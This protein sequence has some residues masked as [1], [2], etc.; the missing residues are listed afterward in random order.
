[1]PSSKSRTVFVCEDCGAQSA[2]W[3]GRCSQCGEWNTLTE[4]LIR[5]SSFKK[6]TS[7]VAS[8]PEKLSDLTVGSEVR[9]EL[10]FQELNRLL[11][12]GLVR[13][14]VVLMSGEPG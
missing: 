13:G 11:G 4:T 2:K 9:I 10:P 12:G 6:S 8:I 7:N 3:G 1:M 5:P 14:S